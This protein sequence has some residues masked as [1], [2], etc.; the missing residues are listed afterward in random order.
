[1]LRSS[2]NALISTATLL[3]PPGAATVKRVRTE[4]RATRRPG[5]SLR[6]EAAATDQRSCSIK[7]AA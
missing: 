6:E 5:M 3:D 1:M 2:S 7:S 4:L